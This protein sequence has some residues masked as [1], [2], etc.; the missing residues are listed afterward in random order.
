M[1][2][3]RNI[4]TALS[5]PKLAAE[6]VGYQF[7]R[8]TR[9]EGPTRTLHEQVKVAGFSGFSEYHSCKKAV[10]DREHRFFRSLNLPPG[11]LIDVGANLGIVTCLMSELWPRRRIHSFEPG[12][13]TFTSL[14]RNL[15]LNGVKNVQAHN[16]AVSDTEGTLTFSFRPDSR[17]TSGFP[18]DQKT[19]ADG[20]DPN[21]IKV[22]S[23]TLDR[24]V[25]SHGI[26][27]ISL[28]K[29]DV[30]GFE[31]LVFR[32]AE[33]LLKEHSILI[34]YFE[35]CPILLRKAGFETTQPTSFLESYGYSLYRLGED[36]M[37]ATASSQAASVALENWIAVS[38][39]INASSLLPDKPL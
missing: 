6:Y 31:P 22:Q 2:T 28:L 21:M 14:Q 10:S 17:A 38:P 32:G 12:P 23:T 18:K 36:G 1:L 37:T 4:T 7:Q 19:H 39:K 24:Y 29:V 30:E 26:P 33:Q 3:F 5:S 20:R 25:A 9:S 34:I 13:S 27:S 16:T 8:L 11:D 15:A 35:M